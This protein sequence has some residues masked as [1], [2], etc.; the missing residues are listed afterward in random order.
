MLSAYRKGVFEESL[1][2]QVVFLG[3]AGAAVDGDDQKVQG[4]NMWEGNFADK[5]SVSVNGFFLAMLS[6]NCGSFGHEGLP[7]V[8]GAGRSTE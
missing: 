3:V 2:G 4:V 1:I 5:K 7:S 6:H 8:D